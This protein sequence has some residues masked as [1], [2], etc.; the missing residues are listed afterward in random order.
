MSIYHLTVK[1]GSRIGGQSALAKSDYI[2]RE[3]RYAKDAEEVEYKESGN[4]PEWAENDPRQY[5]AAADAGERANGRLFR[6]VEFA[7][8]REL[9]AAERVQLATSFAEH[10]TADERLPYTLAVHR[11]GG[12]NP[13]VHLVFSERA[14][15]GI[16]RSAEQWFKRYNAQDPEKGGARKSTASKP[17]EW[18][19]DTREDWADHAN[20]AL[21]RAGSF[22]RITEASLETQYFDAAEDGDERRA[23]ELEHREPGQHMGPHNIARAERGEDVDRIADAQ[24]AADR[25]R[26]RWIER[27]LQQLEKEIRE[28]AQRIAE[29]VKTWNRPS[30]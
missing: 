27:R 26:L 7:L 14:N 19:E 9:N 4:M 25:H 16:E 29:R 15:D 17:R 21:E 5:W 18:L 30:R 20:R 2:E 3:G 12:E 28:V 11:G 8:P 23:A 10:L 1:T 22:G 6:E 13:H 24:D